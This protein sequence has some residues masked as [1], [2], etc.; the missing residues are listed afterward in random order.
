MVDFNETAE[1]A[2]LETLIET[3]LFSRE[4]AEK[5]VAARMAT[6]PAT[7]TAIRATFADCGFDKRLVNALIAFGCVDPTDVLALS[8]W[9]LTV[10]PNVGPKGRAQIEAYRRKVVPGGAS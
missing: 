6:I 1:A 8:R 7:P 10:I 9:Q 5:E 2:Y 3:G 4:E